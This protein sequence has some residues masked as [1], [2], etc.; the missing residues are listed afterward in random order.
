MTQT[1]DAP[2]T[3]APEMVD[4]TVLVGAVTIE[5]GRPNPQ[6]KSQAEVVRVMQNEKI[7]AP[8][9]HPTILS[10]LSM[11]AIRPTADVTG[12]ERITARTMVKVFREAGEVVDAPQVEAVEPIDAPLPVTDP[13][14]VY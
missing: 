8:P 11:K 3:V 6:N 7:T 1:A 13:N 5:T 10:L 12:K 9:S 2:E 4:Y 14:E